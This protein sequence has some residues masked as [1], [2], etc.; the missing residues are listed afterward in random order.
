MFKITKSI[1][2]LKQHKN[3]NILCFGA[4]ELNNFVNFTDSTARS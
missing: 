3:G 2:C 1:D 4:N